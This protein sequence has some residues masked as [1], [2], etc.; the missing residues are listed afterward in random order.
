VTLRAVLGRRTRNP[1]A[2]AEIE[3]EV[4]QAIAQYEVEVATGLLGPGPILVRGYPVAMWL[5]LDV[6]ADLL[7][8]RGRLAEDTDG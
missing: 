8:T 1:V 2:V 3:A 6:L 5:D 4:R 7:A